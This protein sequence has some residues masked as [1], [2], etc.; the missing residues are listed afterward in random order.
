METATEPAAPISFP[1]QVQTGE[2]LV[3]RV[4]RDLERDY[5]GGAPPGVDLAAVARSAVADL[6]GAR[7]KVFLPLLALRAAREALARDR[8]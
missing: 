3:A 7:V 8:S 1:A 5:P 6:K 2:A 4:R